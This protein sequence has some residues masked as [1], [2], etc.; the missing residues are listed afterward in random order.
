MRRL[1]VAEAVTC[2]IRCWSSG[3]RAVTSSIAMLVLFATF[4]ANY[5]ACSDLF[6]R[7]ARF[8]CMFYGKL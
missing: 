8:V 6:Y 3:P 7:D 4:M 5:D 1:A 2:L